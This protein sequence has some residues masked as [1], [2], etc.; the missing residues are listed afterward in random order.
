MNRFITKTKTPSNK[1]E[2]PQKRLQTG[3]SRNESTN[4]KNDSEC[5]VQATPDVQTKEESLMSKLQFAIRNN[6]AQF[7]FDTLST[8]RPFDNAMNKIM[9]KVEFS[10][11]FSDPTSEFMLLSVDESVVDAFKESQRLTIRG[12]STDEAVL[13][14][15]N[16][17]FPIKVIESATTVLLLHNCL[18]APD[19]PT[20]PNFEF[21]S[22]DGKCYSTGELCSAVDVLN[23]GRLKEMLREQELRWDW[24]DKEEEEELLKGYRMNDM[25]DSVQMSVGEL[26]TAL[27]DLPIVKFPNGRYRYLSHKFRGEMLGL[28]AQLLDEDSIEDVRFESISFSGLRAHLPENVPDTVIQ[29]FLQTRCEK[30]ADGSDDRYQL[31]ET[32]LI[33][34]FAVVLLHEVGSMPLRRFSELLNKILP[35]GTNVDNAVFEGIADISDA[36]FGKI[37]TYLGPED[38]PDTVKERMLHLFEYRRLWTMEQLRPYFKDVYKSKMAF[39][40][41]VVLNCEYSLSETNELLY[42][43]VR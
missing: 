28:I 27:V 9:T 24:K 12:E 3:T 23:V 4:K 1:K 17:T 42:C 19:S 40:K 15:D 26:K 43:G 10:S 35:I 18:D 8:N 31:P 13:C 39:D 22:V 37:I 32:N 16:A 36:S 29:W 7:T 33:R 30:I 2:T 38:L 21:E 11:S 41:Y 5:N 6:D 14:T 25:L 20:I 34:D